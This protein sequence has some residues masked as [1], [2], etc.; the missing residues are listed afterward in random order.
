MASGPTD[1]HGVLQKHERLHHAMGGE[2]GDRR[3][4][5]VI[6]ASHLS[7]PHQGLRCGGRSAIGIS[8][9]PL[10]SMGIDTTSGAFQSLREMVTGRSMAAL[11][12]L[13]P[14][15]RGGVL[16]QLPGGRLGH[17]REPARILLGDAQ[18]H[19]DLI[20]P[21]ARWFAAAPAVQA[22]RASPK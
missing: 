13:G 17:E 16:A 19:L 14:Q 11:G 20:A 4:P 8:S 18:E 2:H 6:S 1:S 9:H 15:P 5:T 12:K 3:T 22:W 7:S 10:V 21:R